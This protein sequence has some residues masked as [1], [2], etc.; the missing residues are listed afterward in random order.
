[1]ETYAYSQIAI[2]WETSHN[3]EQPDCSPC[4]RIMEL[5]RLGWKIMFTPE[6]LEIANT[7]QTG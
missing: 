6:L 2:T 1:M 4:D 7:I 5:L 3:I